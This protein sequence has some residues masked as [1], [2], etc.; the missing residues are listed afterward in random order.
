MSRL[1]VVESN[2]TVT[3]SMADHRLRVPQADVEWFARA[4]TNEL[5]RRGIT[6]LQPLASGEDLY[7]F[8]KKWVGAAALDL[9]QNRGE[10]VVVA[11]ASQP[12]RVHALAH[13]INH[14]LGNLDKTVKYG[15][16]TDP[17][18]TPSRES[19]AALAKDAGN[20]TTLI[21]LGGNPVYDAPADLDFA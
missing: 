1:Y 5:V 6:E 3:G 10:S 17:Q 18:G 16:M 20:A 8:D 21:M 11:G 4:L 12:A 13:A 7:G 2:F 15:P 19:I 9:I 14:A